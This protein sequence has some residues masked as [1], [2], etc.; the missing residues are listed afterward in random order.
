MAMSL[1]LFAIIILCTGA[2]APALF[3]W[4][5]N[6]TAQC[7]GAG[8]GIA[9]AALGLSAA[10]AVLFGGQ[11]Q[12]WG[13]A[14][15]P[16]GVGV[17]LRLDGLAAFFLAPVFLLV[18]SCAVYAIRY[19]DLPVRGLQATR[20]WFAFNLLAAS[21]AMVIAAANSLV[22]LVAWEL[23]SLSSFL[24][25]VYDLEDEQV[26]K[27]GWMYLVATHLGT[28]FLFWLFLEENR[29]AGSLDF[30]AFTV[31]GSLPPASVG[32]FF[33]LALIGFGT[34]AGLF[35][36]HGW[37]P[38]AH[39]AAP[40]HVSA[41]MS[42][43]MI[44]TAV[45]AFL[46]LL[47]FLPLLPV[48]CGLLVV[49]LGGLGALFGIVMAVS[50]TDIKRSLAFSTVENIGIIF[51]AL[52]VWLVCRSE[53]LAVAATL[54]LAGG[55][56]HVWNH[57]LFKGLLFQC[58]GSVIHATGSREMS[59]MGGLFARM[60]ATGGLMLL[61]GGALAALPPLN[62]LIGELCIFLGLLHAGQAM[63]GGMAFFFMLLVALLAMVGGLV[64][65]V[66]TRMIGIVLLGE[67]RTAA[68]RQAH[69]APAS[70]LA[71]MAV[72]AVCCLVIGIF[73]QA[74]VRMVAA[75]ISVLAPD[76]MP[77][78][79]GMLGGLPFA[80]G[81]TVSALGLLALV[82]VSLVV[83]GGHRGNTTK[84][85]KTWGCGF[86]RPDPKMAYTAAGFG[87]LAQ[88]EVFASCLRPAIKRSA[89][90]PLFPGAMGFARQS[91][92]PVLGRLVVPFFVKCAGFA[93]YCRRLQAGQLATYMA[94]FFLVTILLL[95]WA[96]FSPQG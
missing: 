19:L 4:R 59:A 16:A 44:K 42:G 70:M 92:D 56:L 68:A 12:E 40:S 5:N 63:S 58:A 57:A 18:L 14:W 49:A 17:T 61:G 85:E 65:L 72:P 76:L 8:C 2:V 87:Q 28:A 30:A 37:L 91:D 46:R 89:R 15:H 31:L 81:W 69:E 6:R 74:A 25:V 38:E 55:L 43:V 93:H 10:V 3:A 22:F 20:H 7:V 26:R 88:D 80:P 32:L 48:W 51:M 60:P 33:L 62:G 35:P 90:A 94:Y 83:I 54:A 75:P 52:G 24:L 53:G 96:I 78:F 11:V 67:P 9:G 73:P 82:T 79:G 36:M 39:A 27:A 21:M 29:L 47:G 86:V 23:M 50:E 66:V 64:L 71:A 95:G 84:T 13:M 34:K 1:F 45:Y 41:L 77:A